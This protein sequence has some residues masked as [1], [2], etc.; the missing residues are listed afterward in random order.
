MVGVYTSLKYWHVLNHMIAIYL[1]VQNEASDGF[2]EAVPFLVSVPAKEGNQYKYD[3]DV[4]PKLDI[5]PEETTEPSTEPTSPPPGPNLPQTGQI[6]WPVPVLAA[7]GVFLITG[8]I[9]L[10]A[11]GKEKNDET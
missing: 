6:N 4:S 1:V 10:R 11:S 8:D 2:L 3:V 7:L 5:A 9:Y